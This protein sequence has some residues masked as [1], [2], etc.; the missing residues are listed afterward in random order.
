[1]LPILQVIT[2]DS[3]VTV[4]TLDSIMDIGNT[5]LDRGGAAGA[6]QQ[7]SLTVCVHRDTR[8]HI[9][10]S[11]GWLEELNYEIMKNHSQND[12]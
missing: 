5:V 9:H 12:K 4:T 8:K 3:R 11:K 1:M 2:Y 7:L 6:A 10:C